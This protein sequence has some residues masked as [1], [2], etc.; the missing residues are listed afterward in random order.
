MKSHLIKG[1]LALLLLLSVKGF[2]QSRQVLF[3]AYIK[4]YNGIAVEEMKKYNIPASITL[5]QGL[6]ES[7]AGQSRLATL[8]NNHFGIKCGGDWTGPYITHDD[9]KK[10]ERFRKYKNPKESFE[11][12]SKFLTGRP[13][14][15]GLFKLE[16]TDYKGWAQGLKDAGYATDKEYPKKLISI[17]E[18][19]KLHQ[20][21]KIELPSV[22]DPETPSVATNHQRYITNGVP[23]IIIR[24]GDTFEL[25][26]EEFRIKK[27]RLLDY[28]DLSDDYQLSANDII[29]L[30]KKKTKAAKKNKIHVV[31]PNESLHNI[32]QKYAIQMKTMYKLNK[33]KFE[34]GIKVGDTIILR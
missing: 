1:L 32:S 14:Y 22:P 33:S 34:S 31:A 7:S 24:K 17:V 12:H 15:Q 27:N 21:D 11:D 4:Q 19:F 29:Y 3:D 23:F 26:H 9:D 28:N 5:A 20:Y 30:K 16:I 2:S 6:L 10:G 25:L 13:W 8:A 18:E